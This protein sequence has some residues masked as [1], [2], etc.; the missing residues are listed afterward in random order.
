[1][2][3]KSAGSRRRMKAA[4]FAF[5]RAESLDHALDQ[6]AQH[7]GDAKPIAGGQSLVPMMA[8]RLAR[9]AVLVDINRL[10]ELKALR[11]GA[12]QRRHGRHHAPAR[13][14]GEHG[15]A[16]R[17]APAARGPALGGPRADAQPRHGGRQ[18]GACRPF[19]RAAAGRRRPG[20]GAAS[21]AA[22]RRASAA[23]P[24]PTSSSRP[25]TPR[26]ARPSAS[27]PSSGRSGRARAC[28][29]AF[30]EA[31]IRHGD[32]AMA[33]AACQLQIDAAGVCRR[34]AVG[35]G[36]VAGTPLAFPDL[37]AELVG[38]PRRAAPGARHRGGRGGALRARFRH[39]RRR[40]VPAPPRRRAAAAR[41]A[42][43]G[44]GQH[45]GPCGLTKGYPACQHRHPSPWRS[46]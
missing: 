43:R 8:M 29:C 3:P 7:G 30:E 36:G 11:I 25:C 6:L 34:A 15:A 35:L 19:G 27:P 44:C 38:P 45:A 5:V 9:P 1:M 13:R 46:W 41:P 10:P 22:G 37:A 17:R 42:A 21:C 2:G 28:H 26:P 32:F 18:P 39:P 12:P 24:P 40:R 14:G 20:R 4:P 23:W 31:A 33:S 16:R